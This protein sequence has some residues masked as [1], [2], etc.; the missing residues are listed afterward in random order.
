MSASPAKQAQVADRRAKAIAM[1]LA[2]ADW[3]GIA[4]ALGYASRGA[5][6]TDVTR[7]LKA[8]REAEAEKVQEL[9]NVENLR[10]NR[11]QAAFW[12]KALKGDTK[13]AEIVLKCVAGRGRINGT[14][15]PVRAELTGAGGGPIAFTAPEMDEFEA[16]LTAGDVTTP[17]LAADLEDAGGDGD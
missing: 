4:D 1:Y 7:A 5:A 3:Q 17:A 11:L 16:L 13:A 14:D 12:P 15:A 2:G 8:N 6:H 9:R 10:L